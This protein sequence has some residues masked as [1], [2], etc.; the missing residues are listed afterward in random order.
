MLSTVRARK[1]FALAPAAA[2]KLQQTAPWPIY[3]E[4]LQQLLQVHKPQAE[5]GVGASAVAETAGR[6]TAIAR[7][8]LA[9]RNVQ[10]Y[11]W[12]CGMWQKVGD[13]VQGGIVSCSTLWMDGEPNCV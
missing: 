12:P 13:W 5:P 4:M 8:A 1:S 3:M 6:T 7:A 9:L 2:A 10:F 11:P